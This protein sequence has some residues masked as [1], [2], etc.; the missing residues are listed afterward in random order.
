MT[1]SFHPLAPSEL[2]GLTAGS[3]QTCD[4]SASVP[5]GATGVILN[6]YNSNSIYDYEFG[7][8][9]P[10]DTN[11]TDNSEINNASHSNGFVGVNAN[12]EFQYYIE[13]TSSCHLYLLGYTTAGVTFLD[14]A[15]EITSELTP[16]K[17]TDYDATNVTS[18]D[19]TAIIVE[20]G[21]DVGA[22]A[23][24]QAVRCKGSSDTF[25]T[26]LGFHNWIISKCDASQVIE[27]YTEGGSQTV[28]IVGYVTDGLEGMEVTQTD[29]SIEPV[30]TWQT[31]TINPAAKMAIF[32]VDCAYTAQSYGF[33]K[34]SDAPEYFHALNYTQAWY[35]TGCDD[36]G[37][38]LGKV[39]AV[40]GK[41][42]S[43]YLVGYSAG[44]VA[45]SVSDTS[46]G[47]EAITKFVSLTLSDTGA[48]Y[49]CDAPKGILK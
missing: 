39:S 1:Q 42:V 7:L 18:A 37:N 40:S 38:C 11:H 25:G 46:T 49:E 28:F 44:V 29:K 17:W 45:R 12:R 19:A 20:F 4:V 8:R 36:N 34:D 26:K 31:I 2:T 30:E 9:K 6:L 41:V 47:T 35:A 13:S 27:I 21:G 32:R 10:G 3:W 43:F 5:S 23:A 16:N 14:A 15:V 48:G 24:E 22:Y 33:R